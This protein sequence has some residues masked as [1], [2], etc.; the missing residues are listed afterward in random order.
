MRVKQLRS[1]PVEAEAV[2]V[3]WDDNDLLA[4]EAYPDW[5]TMAI[6]KGIVQSHMVRNKYRCFIIRN[7]D[8]KA[9]ASVAEPGEWIIK[10]S[11]GYYEGMNEV[12]MFQKYEEINNG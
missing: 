1:K 6:Q 8:D 3:I 9:T 7:P 11:D 4:L 12:D 2:K 5:I 10:D